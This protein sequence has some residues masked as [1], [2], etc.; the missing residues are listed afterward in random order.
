MGDEGVG[1]RNE[2]LPSIEGGEKK[3]ESV[4]IHSLAREPTVARIRERNAVHTRRDT[5]NG[6]GRE[7]W[8]NDNAAL[9]RRFVN[10]LE[11]MR[12]REGEVRRVNSEE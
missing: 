3:K 7:C 9:E 11:K 2:F 4:R 1:P 5:H 8:E 12:R 6:D 10:T